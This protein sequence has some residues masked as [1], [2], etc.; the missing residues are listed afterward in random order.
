M[1]EEEEGVLGCTGVVLPEPC[2][3]RKR[4][5][6][7]ARGDE[8][9]DD[10]MVEPLRL[11]LA[12]ALLPVL[13][14]CDRCCSKSATCALRH[15]LSCLAWDSAFLRRLM[16]SLRL[17]SLVEAAFWLCGRV[18]L[19]FLPPLPLTAVPQFGHEICCGDEALAVFGRRERGLRTGAEVAW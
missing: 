1:R 12:L 16:F 19:P 11:L 13:L 2:T 3:A 8:A 10:V 6:E 18:W 15:S 17:C 14:P 9:L 5:E 7:S 4:G